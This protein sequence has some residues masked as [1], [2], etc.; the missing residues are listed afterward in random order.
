MPTSSLAPATLSKMRQSY[1][2]LEFH[3][4]SVNSPQMFNIAMK[5]LLEKLEE[6]G[7]TG[8]AI[9]Y[10]LNCICIGK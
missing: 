7:I 5:S 8:K 2:T 10:D 6:A 4:G 1:Q 3:K 9:A